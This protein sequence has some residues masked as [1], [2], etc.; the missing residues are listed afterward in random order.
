MAEKAARYGPEL[1]R[2]AEKSLVLQVLDQQW[3]DHLLHLDHLRQGI[4][5]RAYG[6]RDPLNEYKSEAFNLFQAML[7]RF[8]ETV[9]T[10]LSHVE[11]QSNPSDAAPAQSTSPANTVSRLSSSAR[12]RGTNDDKSSQTFTGLRPSRGVLDTN[13]PSTWGKIGRNAPC[14]CGSDK[15]YKHCHGAVN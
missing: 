1:M 9:T 3:K 15:K 13:D 11:F 8:R 14:P 2:A 4:G 12:T 5:L 6:Q 10:L 7:N